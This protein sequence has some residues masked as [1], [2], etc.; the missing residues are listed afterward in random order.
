MAKKSD[1]KPE[2]VKVIT[3][4]ALR[5]LMREEAGAD[6]VAADC[7]LKLL[8]YLQDLAVETTKKAMKISENAKRKTI[9]KADIKLAIVGA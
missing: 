5:R 3:K 8:D 7:V 6:I 2:N 9:T 4:T 1:K